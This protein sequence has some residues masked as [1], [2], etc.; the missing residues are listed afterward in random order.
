MFLDKIGELSPSVQAKLLRL[1]QE[2]EVRPVGSV[3]SHP[4]D[5]RIIAVTNR[6]LEEEVGKGRF[7]EDL[8]C[9]ERHGW[10][11]WPG[12]VRE[13]E[14]VIRRALVLGTKDEIA[15]SDLPPDICEGVE[16]TDGAVLCP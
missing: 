1:L 9:L 4:V 10:H 7:R 12:N 3:K 8:E 11:G 15:L 2:Y 13:L 5:V 6:D 14:N 16:T